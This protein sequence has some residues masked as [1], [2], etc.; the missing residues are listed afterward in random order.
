VTAADRGGGRVLL[1]GKTLVGGPKSRGR[2][3]ALLGLDREES[4]GPCRVVAAAWVQDHLELEVAGPDGGKVVFYLDRNRDD[5]PRLV[6]SRNLVLY[7]RGGQLWPGLEA[8]VRRTGLERLA[9]KTVEDLA[10]LVAG[11]DQVDPARDRAPQVDGG[12][13]QAFDRQSLLSTWASGDLWYQFFATAEIGRARLDSL[14]IFDRCTFIQHCDRDCL[15][16][17]PRTSVAMVER[18]FYPWHDRVRRVGR[19]PSRAAAGAVALPGVSAAEQ[20]HSMCTTDLGE[21]DV[22][23]G[24][25]DKLTR[26]LDHVIARGVDNMLFLSCTCVPFMTGEDVESLVKRYRARTDKPFF[27]LTTTPQSSAGVFREVLVRRRQAAEEQ[28]TDVDP[29]SVNLIGYGRGPALDELKGLLAAAGVRV[30]A[31]FIPEM[32]FG[33]IA[34]LPRAPLHVMYPNAA[35]QAIYDQLLFASRVRSVAPPAP[36]GI[37]GTRRWL[38]EVAAAVGVT[39]DVDAAVAQRLEPLRAAWDAARARAATQRLGFVVGAGEVYRLCDPGATW[40][41]PLLAFAEEMGFGIDVM[42]GAAERGAARQA[43]EQVHAVFAAPARHTIR[44]FDDPA[45]LERL[46]TQ[47]AF[48]AVFSEHLFDRRLSAAGKAQF[49]LQE[50]EPGL[51]GAVRT[52]ERLLRVCALPFYRRYHQYLEAD[53]R[54]AVTA[55]PASGRAA[56]PDK[57]SS[58][59]TA[60][61]GRWA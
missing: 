31:V 50:F 49:S 11:D 38:R 3:A 53:P 18:V 57:L 6:A 24:G 33:A 44:A 8:R 15:Q 26:V 10:E 14:D 22:V 60:A 37:E 52:A 30:N 46:L 19:A 51:A 41:V 9:G 20:R 27:Y 39:P 13:Q 23:M 59:G 61:E 28:V 40:G 4:A 58:P 2:L 16:V 47:G 29:R 55:P 32:N 48:A 17:S 45:R 25:L 43:A 54:P 12:D 34:D 21:H 5:K 7:Y 36:F 1:Q 56:P 35:W 42:L